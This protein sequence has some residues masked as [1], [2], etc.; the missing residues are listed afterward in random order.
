MLVHPLDVRQRPQVVP[1]LTQHHVAILVVFHLLPR[2]HST[3]KFDTV[4]YSAL[5]Y[6]VIYRVPFLAVTGE[7]APMRCP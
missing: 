5:Q 4:Q 1:H 3:V 6:S 2:Q 7:P